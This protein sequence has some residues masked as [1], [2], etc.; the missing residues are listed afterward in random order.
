MY[1]LIKPLRDR[2]NKLAYRLKIK[3][4][5]KVYFV[6][7]MCYK[8]SVYDGIKL[9]TG[10]EKIYLEWFA[11]T[12]ANESLNEYARRMAAGIDTK[13]PF[14]LIGYSLGGVIIQEMNSFVSPVKNIVI[15]SM[16]SENEIPALFKVAKRGHLANLVPDSI[17]EA[18]EFIVNIFSK[19]VYK[20]SAELLDGYMICTDPMYVKWGVQQITNWQPRYQCLRLYHIHGSEDQIFPAK[21]IEDAYIVEEA[22]HLMV[23]THSKEVNA[24][25]DEILSKK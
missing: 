18:T 9:P 19:T 5:T 13:R 12:S 24:I 4:P 11:P 2:L 14:I 16:T 23:L 10:F 21:Q 8:C 15:S 20:M 22:D 7:G 1:S 17:F 25:I 3:K 6:S